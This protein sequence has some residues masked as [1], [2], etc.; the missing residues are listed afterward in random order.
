VLAFL[1]LAPVRFY[2]L[3]HRDA[4]RSPSGLS[5]IARDRVAPSLIREIERSQ[6][7][8][9]IWPQSKFRRCIREGR[10]PVPSY[11]GRWPKAADRVDSSLGGI[12]HDEK[13]APIRAVKRFSIDTD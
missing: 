7:S 8:R 5:G 12:G 9:L 1:G 11:L 3:V 6:L 4:L 10:D 13:Q 2:L